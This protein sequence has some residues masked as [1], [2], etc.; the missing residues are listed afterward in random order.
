MTATVPS[1]TAHVSGTLRAPTPS[2]PE[3]CVELTGG[4]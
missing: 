2:C 3:P 1:G 4:A